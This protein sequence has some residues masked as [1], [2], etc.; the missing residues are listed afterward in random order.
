MP[1]L[2]FQCLLSLVQRY[3]H[4]LTKQQKSQ[5]LKLISAHEHHEICPEI[6]HEITHSKRS[7]GDPEVD[8]EDMAV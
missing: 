1:V 4:D 8:E 6:R 7:R 3:K 5:L 2:W